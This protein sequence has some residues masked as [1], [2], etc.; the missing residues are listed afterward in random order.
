MF[1]QRNG[2]CPGAVSRRSIVGKRQKRRRV[3]RRRMKGVAALTRL[4]DTLLPDGATPVR[5]WTPRDD[6]IVPSSRAS[7]VFL[8]VFSWADIFQVFEMS[9]RSKTNKQTNKT[10]RN[11]KDETD[12][13]FCWFFFPKFI[14]NDFVIRVKQQQQQQQQ[15]QLKKRTVSDAIDGGP[16]RRRHPLR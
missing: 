8:L 9:S 11:N 3:R 15:Q 7:F 16:R 1:N 5:W 14:S 2:G 10:K 12:C 13:L 4:A 6:V